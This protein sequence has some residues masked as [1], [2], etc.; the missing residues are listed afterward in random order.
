VIVQHE[1]AFRKQEI[2]REA[3]VHAHETFYL[4]LLNGLDLFYM[5]FGE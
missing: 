4:S 1:T 5:I 2:L 3:E